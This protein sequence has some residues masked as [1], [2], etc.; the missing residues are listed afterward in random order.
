MCTRINVFVKERLR[1]CTAGIVIANYDDAAATENSVGE[2]RHR[3]GHR[4]HVFE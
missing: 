2:F 4:P 3:I 1:V